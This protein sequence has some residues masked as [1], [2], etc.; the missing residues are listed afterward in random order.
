MSSSNRITCSK[1]KSEGFSIP[2]KTT[3]GKGKGKESTNQKNLPD[4]AQQ[5]TSAT[6]GVQQLQQQAVVQLSPLSPHRT[7]PTSSQSTTG[8]LDGERPP[9]SALPVAGIAED[10]PQS[11]PPRLG[12]MHQKQ[13]PTH[14]VPPSPARVG[15]PQVPFQT[16]SQ[17][18]GSHLS[19]LSAPL[20][21]ED[22][23]STSTDDDQE[24]FDS[25]VSKITRQ[26]TPPQAT[27]IVMLP[28]DQSQH[29]P[30][31]ITQPWVI[32]TK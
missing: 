5:S 23:Y 30:Q 28:R 31:W 13:V 10:Q 4:M 2:Y 21:T 26:R 1:G 7:R 3:K 20:F 16:L 25:E 12:P 11:T 18:S 8:P 15:T 9:S 14:A 19:Q 22:R 6:E 17:N 27:T 29:L 24:D 32:Q